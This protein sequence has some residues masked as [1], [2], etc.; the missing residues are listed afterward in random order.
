MAT[1]HSPEENDLFQVSGVNVHDN[2]IADCTGWTGICFGGYDRDLGFTKDCEFDHNT[3]VDN[4]TQIGI[5]RS[6]NNR[7]Y[8]NLFLGGETG[9]EFSE[10]CREEDMDND[11]SDNAA[12]EIEDEDSW[13]DE[14]G[15]F[16]SDRGEIAEGFKS[17]LEDVGSRFIP[18]EG[19]LEL[20]QENKS[21]RE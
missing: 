17:L 12:A 15:L 10:D 9:I 4:S 6:R 2:V 13:T 18:D 7:V 8:A 14:Y 3:L 11:I 5:Q 20:Y 21:G 19:M 16:Y 1:E